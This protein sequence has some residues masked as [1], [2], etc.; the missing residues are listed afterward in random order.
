MECFDDNSSSSSD[1]VA[2]AIINEI[3]EQEQLLAEMYYQP[4][5]KRVVHHRQY[6]HR[7]REAVHLCLMQDYFNDNPTHGLTFFRRC[8]R[9]QKELFLRIIETI[10]GED[11]YFQISHDAQGRDS[12]TPLQKY[13][14][15]F[16]QLATDVNADTF[17]EYL[18]VA[19]TTGRL[20]L[21]RFCKAVIRAFRAEYLRRPTQADIQRLLQ[22]HEARHGFFGML[23]SLDWE[24]TLILEAVAFHD[25]WIWHA[26]FDV[27]GSNNGI[28]FLNQL[29]LFS[30]VLDGTAAPVVFEA[31]RRYYQMGYYLCDGIY[32]EWRCFVKSQPM[33]TNL[34]DARF[35]KDVERAFGVL[36]ARWGIIQSPARGWYVD[37][38][39]EIMMC[40]IILHNMIVEKEG[41]IAAHWTDDDAGHG[42][43]NS[44][45]S[46]SARA[47]PV[48]F[49]EYVQINAIFR[50]RQIHAQLQRD[51]IE[52]VWYVSDL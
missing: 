11:T 9:M 33:A 20:Y 35:K 30:D 42:A 24:P 46:E 34:K 7:D 16:S 25:L 4:A 28:N 18:K 31:N 38:L 40:C 48:C 15:A 5:P 1:E 8:F 13:T 10:Q 17:N 41:E 51:L 12:L 36:Q 14:A 50:D 19:D 37:N 52:H 29:P 32:P 27:A 3:Q 49:E 21:K 2:Q 6:V 26:F 39:K 22:M 47:T 45:S 43:S 23:G 44:D